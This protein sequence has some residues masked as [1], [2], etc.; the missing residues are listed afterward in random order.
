MAGEKPIERSN[1]FSIELIMMTMENHCANYEQGKVLLPLMY[2][3][4]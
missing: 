2:L 1:R 3:E 4:Y